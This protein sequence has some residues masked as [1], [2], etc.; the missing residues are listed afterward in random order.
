MQICNTWN[1]CHLQPCL[2]SLATVCTDV[3][4][5]HVMYM[6]YVLSDTLTHSTYNC[7]RHYKGSWYTEDDGHWNKILWSRFKSMNKRW[8]LLLLLLSTHCLLTSKFSI[9]LHWSCEASPF[10]QNYVFF[11]TI[12]INCKLLNWEWLCKHWRTLGINK[13][14]E[15]KVN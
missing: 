4:H 8:V 15:S 7:S 12:R 5:S 13:T 11:K 1:L 3:D 6:F 10:K 14:S 9:L 2:V